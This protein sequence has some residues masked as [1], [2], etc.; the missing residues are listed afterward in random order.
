MRLHVRRYP[1]PECSI[2][3]L[4]AHIWI[5]PIRSTIRLNVVSTILRKKKTCCKSFGCHTKQKKLDISPL[6]SCFVFSSLHI[7]LILFL[8]W[9]L[10]IWM[11][12]RIISKLFNDSLKLGKYAF[13]SL[14]GLRKSVR[15]FLCPCT[16]IWPTIKSPSTVY[17]H[18]WA[19]DLISGHPTSTKFRCTVC[20]CVSVQ[21]RS[22]DHAARIPYV[23]HYYAAVIRVAG[24]QCKRQNDCLA[25]HAQNCHGLE[26]H[27]VNLHAT[28]RLLHWQS[29]FEPAPALANNLLSD[30][31]AVYRRGLATGH[32]FCNILWICLLLTKSC[33]WISLT[34]IERN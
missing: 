15:A 23:R 6:F 7:H 4:T 10:L 16:A 26:S 13:S 18:I 28:K 1:W 25:P 33:I 5:R 2:P 24:C 20:L 21:T 12:S 27:R 29:N 30:H 3:M 31:S 11:H 32:A 14:G 34:E 9:S 8:F 22:S 19:Y 17:V